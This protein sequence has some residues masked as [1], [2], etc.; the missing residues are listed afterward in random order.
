LLNGP[1]IEIGIGQSGEDG[2]DSKVVNL[3]A[4]PAYLIGTM[5][6]TRNI[7]AGINQ[8]ILQSGYF[9]VFATDTGYSTGASFRCLLTLI[10]E[11]T[12]LTDAPFNLYIYESLYARFLF[13][14]LFG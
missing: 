9:R 5:G 11:H 2:L 1:G 6:I 13:I 12:H 8:K 4:A 14:F 7:L 10:T 3:I